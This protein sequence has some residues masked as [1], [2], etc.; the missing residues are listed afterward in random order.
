MNKKQTS[1]ARSI[2][3]RTAVAVFISELIYCKIN[4]TKKIKR[5]V[6]KVTLA[7]NEMKTYFG[8]QIINCFQKAGK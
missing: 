3:N 1:V 6:D 2:S 5:Y 8:T 4:F 7:K